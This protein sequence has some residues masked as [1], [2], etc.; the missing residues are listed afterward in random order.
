M[1]NLKIIITILIL[2][3]VVP[4]ISVYGAPKKLTIGL[5]FE[6]TLNERWSKEVKFFVAEIERLGGTVVLLDAQ[7]NQTT[8]NSQIE[9]LISQKVD[10]LVVLPVNPKDAAASVASAKKAGI[11]VMAYSRIILNANLDCFVGSDVMDSGRTLAK[12]A[13]AKVPKGNYIIINGAPTDLNAKLEQQGYMEVLKPYIA[14]KDINIVFEQ[15][16]DNWDT[17][18]AMAAT[19]NALTQTK[20]KIDVA[21]V[22]NDSMATGVV[23]AL[24]AQKLAGK[25]FV[26]GINAEIAALQRIAEGTQAVTLLSPSKEFAVAAAQGAFEMAKTK[27][28]PKLA[29]GKVNNGFKDIPQI[30]INTTLVVQK[31]MP[32][33]V[34]KSG[35]AKADD[36]YKNI[37]KEK[38]PK[39]N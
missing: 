25:V 18:K 30:K 11:P 6:N 10:V 5:A 28:A 15:W 14:R 29:T 38:W 17:D 32:E 31:N 1:K 4:F 2:L 34:I 13:V 24:K 36:V 26:T 37:P 8:Q 35:F 20:N 39:V 21:L 33:T 19:E 12:A 9:K 16:C 27:K 7:G 23:Q 3:M 22:A